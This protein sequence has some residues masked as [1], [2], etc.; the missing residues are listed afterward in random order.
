MKYKVGQKVAYV[1]PSFAG[2]LPPHLTAPIPRKV[3]TVRGGCEMPGKL[4]AMARC[5]YGYLLEEI[6]NPVL[7]CV[8]CGVVMEMH[9]PELMLRPL[10]ERKNDGEAFVAGLRPLLKQPE[11]LG[12][13][14]VQEWY[15]QDAGQ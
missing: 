1:G 7:P 9:I 10:Q 5:Q 6:V 11:R 15:R 3:Y 14:R 12:V 8:L 13:H 2:V 4:Q